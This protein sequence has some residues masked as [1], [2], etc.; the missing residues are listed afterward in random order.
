MLD[1]KVAT[2]IFTLTGKCILATV[3]SGFAV[4]YINVWQ[5]PYMANLIFHP[6]LGLAAT[7]L[8]TIIM[9]KML[10]SRGK[11]LRFHVAAYFPLAIVLVLSL[12]IFGLHSKRIVFPVIVLLIIL[13]MF[14]YRWL[15]RNLTPDW[16]GEVYSVKLSRVL[17]FYLWYLLLFSGLIIIYKSYYGGLRHIFFVHLGLSFLFVICLA[18]YLYEIIRQKKLNLFPGLKRLFVGSSASRKL[19]L[20]VVSLVVLYFLGQ[21]LV[22]PLNPKFTVNLSAIPLE[23]RLEEERQVFFQDDAFPPEGMNLVDSCVN[24]VGCHANMVEPYYQ[25]VHNFSLS[26]PHF[27]KNLSALRDELGMENTLICA[28]CHFPYAL[29]DKTKDFKYFENH[30]NL[31]CS[32]CHMIDSAVVNPADNRRARYQINAPMGHLDIFLENGRETVPEGLKAVFIKL[33]PINHG[34]AF[35][36]KLHSQD[37][38]CIVCHHHQLKLYPPEDLLR[39]KCMDCHMQSQKYIGYEG[40]IRNHLMP[41]AN[42]AVP[43]FAGRP[44]L[45]RLI[46]AWMEG[47]YI[48]PLLGWEKVWN[49]E[50]PDVGLIPK[51]F[52]LN[53]DVDFADPPV[54]GKLFKGSIITT[55]IGMEHD[56]PAGPLDLVEA[57]LEIIVENEE[58][59]VL[60]KMDEMHTEGLTVE[61]PVRLGGYYLDSEGKLVVQNRV[62]DIKKK[63]VEQ[64]IEPGRQVRSEFFFMV[65]TSLRGPLVISAKWNYRKLNRGFTTWAYGEDTVAPFVTVGQTEARIKLK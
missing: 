2:K 57:W 47:D 64:V 28:G 18:Y 58:G 34:R 51:I 52:W 65:P 11:G 48:F 59:D 27:Q 7:A 26:T 6:L 12:P 37:E 8:M 9:L 56:F 63:V 13:F 43:Y 29:F 3:V 21:Y 36:Q 4:H 49:Y 16:G 39:P 31:S 42:V 35:T 5:W 61:G 32:F 55:N 40:E 44:D 22:G 25:S 50:K 30:N 19:A 54:V 24:G 53:V 17:L 33:S 38:F 45:V 14:H 1:K 10:G 15:R 60:Y 20:A 46:N 41:G 62:W 23:D